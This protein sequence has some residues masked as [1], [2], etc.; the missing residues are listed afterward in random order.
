MSETISNLS[1]PINITHEYIGF[2]NLFNIKWIPV[3]EA[4]A[5]VIQ[6][7]EGNNYITIAVVL[8]NEFIDYEIFKDV[9]QKMISTK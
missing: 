9:Y 1:A 7:L 5:Y 4:G 2:G 8:T 3:D 6:R